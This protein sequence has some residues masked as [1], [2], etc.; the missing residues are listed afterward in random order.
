MKWQMAV[1]GLKHAP[2]HNGLNYNLGKLLLDEDNFTGPYL[3]LLYN[4]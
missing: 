2:E 3:L 1:E 4:S